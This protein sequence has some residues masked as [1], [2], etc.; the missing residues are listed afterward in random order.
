MVESKLIL[1]D[2]LI[3]SHLPSVGSFYCRKIKFAEFL[4]F[5]KIFRQCKLWAVSRGKHSFSTG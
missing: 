4:K 1:R 3:I 5:S 2:M